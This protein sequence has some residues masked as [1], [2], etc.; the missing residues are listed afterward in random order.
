MHIQNIEVSVEEVN[1]NVLEARQDI[2]AM[3]TRVKAVC[4]SYFEAM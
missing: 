2:D 1:E 3:H 4:Q